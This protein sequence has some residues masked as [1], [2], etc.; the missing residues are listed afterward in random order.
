MLLRSGDG[1]SSGMAVG[2]QVSAMDGRRHEVLGGAVVLAAG[3]IE[4][5]RI[6]MLSDP[7]GTGLGSGREHT[8]RFLQDHP[9]VDLLE[10]DPT[11]PA[12]LQ[13]RT[14]H[15]YRGG[16]R[17]WPKVRLA[18]D[19]QEAERLLDANAVVVHEH[20]D[21]AMD[22]ARRLVG[23]LRRRSLPAGW[24][25][26]VRASV[27]AVGPLLRAAYRRRFRG[28]SAGRPATR[29]V[30]QVW[31]EQEPDAN[32]RL[33]LGAGLD[34]L[35]LP[36]AEVDWRVG[37]A[38]LRTSRVLARWVAEDLQAHGLATVT[39]LPA[40][41]DDEAWRATVVDAYHPSGTTRM[42]S[43]PVD[44][45]V[46]A[47]GRVHGVE[48]LFV[49]GSSVFPV[50]GYANPTLTIVALALRLADHLVRSVPSLGG[51]VERAVRPS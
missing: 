14:A 29:T 11:D 51:Q 25:A 15:L 46:D 48:R 47:D 24:P 6:L 30:L 5:A 16:T 20:D 28:L 13:D 39:E 32:S 50:A 8:G 49:A 23:G 41:T 12:G 37:P 22:A 33:R 1:P 42:S 44:G 34:P 7:A 35:G 31:L 3:A 18:P 17:L 38:E 40:M 9:V 10:L 45:V 26:D 4:N 21:A 19:A 43:S 2:V 27:G 36:V